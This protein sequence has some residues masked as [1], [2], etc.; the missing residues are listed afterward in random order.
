[1]YQ[2][3]E[4]KGKMRKQIK[5]LCMFLFLWLLALGCGGC[6][7][8]TGAGLKGY[9]IYRVEGSDALELTQF[10]IDLAKQETGIRLKNTADEEENWISLLS[11]EGSANE[12]GYTVQGMGP[13]AFTIARDGNRLFLLAGTDAGLKRGCRY[14]F[15]H[16]VD[17]QGR[18]LLDDGE[19]YA[20]AGQDMKDGIYIGS[21]PVAEYTIFYGDK[22]AASV[23]EELR[24]FIYRT[25]GE[26]LPVADLKNPGGVWDRAVCG[27]RIG[28][29]DGA[30]RNQERGGFH[31]GGG[32]GC[33][34]AGNVSVREHLS[35]MDGRRR[36]RCP[37]QQRR[38]DDLCAG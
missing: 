11:E 32:R 9:K 17:G 23:C 8:E 6:G 16:L 28:E 15:V 36:I 35:G 24:E 5:R 34:E 13:N 20:D 31:S 7:S 21:T 14:L 25:D 37:Y 27:Q 26:L 4:G 30:D 2:M 38:G 29:R 1:M 12:Y 33:P 19:T 22:S 3:S 10:V 18:L